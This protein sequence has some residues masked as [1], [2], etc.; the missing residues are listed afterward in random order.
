MMEIK[1]I[2][3]PIELDFIE[4][5]QKILS[6]V[7]SLSQ[8]YGAALHLLYVLRDPEGYATYYAPHLN[9]ETM[10][11][12]IAQEARKKLNEYVKDN[13]SD[14]R[15]VHTLVAIGGVAREIVAYANDKK[16]DLIVM[17]THGRKGLEAAF[18]G[19]VAQ[20]VVKNSPVP[21]LTVNPTM[22]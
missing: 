21:V 19:S 15:E 7:R 1:N 9:L 18:F 16:I 17:G 3:F 2:L 22:I 8:K 11:E 13:L 6:Y 4:G 20:K 10:V 5:N 14:C 12:E